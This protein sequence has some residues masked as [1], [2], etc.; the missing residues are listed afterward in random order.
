[1]ATHVGYLLE[2]PEV[3]ARV[4]RDLVAFVECHDIRPVVGATF[5]FDELPQAH[6]LMESR[7]SV[8]KIVVRVVEEGR[9]KAEWRA[10][11]E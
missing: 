1:M 6:A 8:G 3:L 5:D 10:G 11:R 9:A 7:R 2:R 4:W